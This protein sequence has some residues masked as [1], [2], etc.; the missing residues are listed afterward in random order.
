LPL[1][2][3]VTAVPTTGNTITSVTIDF[4]DGSPPILLAGSVKS[5][6]HTYA[7]SGTYV[8]TATATDSG[9]STGVG[10][11]VIAVGG[12]NASF[13]TTNGAALSKTVNF[14]AAGS[15]SSSQITTYTWDF[16]DGTA[17]GTG[18]TTTHTYAGAGPF[19][20]RLTVT[21]S[22]GRTAITTQSV[23]PP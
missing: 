19:I 11:T 15:S 20:V 16:G 7:A 12:I 17:N 21:D 1:T 14:N 23:T 10:T 5:V 2:F 3:T 18:V 4:G 13:T 6:V 8:V 9:G 22:A